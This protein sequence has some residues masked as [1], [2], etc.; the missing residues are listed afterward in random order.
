[1]YYHAECL[2]RNEEELLNDKQ[3]G[4]PFF[5]NWA[6][7]FEIF[8]KEW[9]KIEEDSQFEKMEEKFQQDLQHARA[10]NA[11]KIPKRKKMH[12]LWYE[13][14]NNAHNNAPANGLPAT[15]PPAVYLSLDASANQKFSIS[16]PHW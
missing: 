12:Q 9:A 2:G 8:A 1:M 5:C 6:Q 13:K 11:T 3:E 15:Q 10:V 16:L 14:R 4:K 7:P